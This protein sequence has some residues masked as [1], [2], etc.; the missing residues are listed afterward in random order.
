MYPLFGRWL[1]SEIESH[2]P[3]S[4]Q[5]LQDRTDPARYMNLSDND[6]QS[7]I[8]VGLNMMQESLLS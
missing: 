8:R 5:Q 1:T 6:R 2:H 3:K 4:H 7:S